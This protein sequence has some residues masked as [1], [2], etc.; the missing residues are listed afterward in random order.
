MK[1]N[2]L[3]FI[4]FLAVTGLADSAYLTWKHFNNVIPP[5]TI[6]HFL[7]IISDCGKVLRS[8]YS[9]MFGIPLALFGVLQY[10]TLLIVIISFI[11][12]RKKIFSY[13]ILFQSTIGAIFSL[14]FMYLQLIVLKSICIYCTLSALISFTIFFLSYKIFFKERFFIRLS[15]LSFLYQKILKPIFFLMD[16]EFVHETM[17]TTGEIIGKTFVKNYFNWKLNYQ[18]K[19]LKQ[20]IAGINFRGSIGLA[21]G[22]DYNGQLSQILSSLGFAFQTIGTITNLPY[23]GNSK[24]RLGRLPKSRSLMVNKGFKNKGAKIICENLIQSGVKGF[25]IPLG[26][27]IGVSNNK[28]LNNLEDSIN[29]IKK[30]ISVAQIYLIQMLIFITQPI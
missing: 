13:W 2:F 22:F 29:D 7:P 1:K 27:S 17:I 15:A 18:S 9:V 16:A 10:L 21:A 24:P 26:I 25:Q 14:Y 11:Y 4:L 20:K 19:K 30:E 3:Y 8:S 12:W 23:E 28:S 6:N 5:C